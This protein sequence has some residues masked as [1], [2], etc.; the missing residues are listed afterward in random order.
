M[1]EPQDGLRHEVADENVRGHR[2]QRVGIAPVPAF[3]VVVVLESPVHCHACHGLNALGEADDLSV[4]VD[5][6]SVYW[7]VQGRL[8]QFD[9][10]VEAEGDVVQAIAFIPEGTYHVVWKACGTDA[11]V[12]GCQ[13]VTFVNLQAPELP[14]LLQDDNLPRDIVGLEEEVLPVRREAE[15]AISI[16]LELDHELKALGHDR[17]HRK[18]RCLVHDTAGLVVHLSSTEV[19]VVLRNDLGEV[20][21]GLVSIEHGEGGRSY[22]DSD[23][24]AA[25][26]SL[27]R[28]GRHVD[29]QIPVD[30]D[31]ILL[32]GGKYRQGRGQ[33]QQ[34]QQDAHGC[35]HACS[36]LA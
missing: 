26:E 13:L 35:L 22:V 36:P 20:R 1:Q 16:V 27:R 3:D 5:Y 31:L 17:P 34:G 15:N 2:Q 6:D 30:D 32:S 25:S 19:P 4:L 18:G 9:P 21:I 7:H 12:H 14:R 11:E 24:V 10:Y 33:H 29:L 28:A 8:D 23:P